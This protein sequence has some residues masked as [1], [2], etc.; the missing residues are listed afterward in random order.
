MAKIS[1]F[2]DLVAWQLARSLVKEIYLI[3]KTYPNEEIYGLTSQ[4][5]RAAI[6]IPSNI[7]EGFS[8]RGSKDYA[9]FLSIALGSLLELETQVILSLDLDYINQANFDLVVP[10]IT[11]LKKVIFALRKAVQAF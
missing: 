11:E 7:A 6:S 2:K 8:R 9:N 10:K 4:M 1:D 3:T 5:R